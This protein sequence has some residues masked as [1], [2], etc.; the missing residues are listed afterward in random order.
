MEAQICDNAVPTQQVLDALRQHLPYSLP[1]LRRLQFMKTS[2]VQTLSSHV[3]SSFDAE[4]PGKDFLVASLDLS[5]C[6]ETEMWLYSSIENPD[7]PGDEI[8]CETQILQL[9][10]RVRELERSYQ[11]RRATP[12]IVMV[13]TLHKTILEILEKHSMVKAKTEEHFKFIF[14]MGEL[15][16]G[17]PLPENLSWSTINPSDISLV[18]SRTEIPYQAFAKSSSQTYVHGLMSF[19]GQR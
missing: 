18:L 10:E 16:P 13:A 11:G 15:P 5:K 7:R 3:L 12:G 19:V 2:V 4:A 6:P 17:K 14:K 8:A 1:T 9:F